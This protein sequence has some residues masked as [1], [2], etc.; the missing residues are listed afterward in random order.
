MAG[1]AIAIST[2]LGTSGLG[3]AGVVGGSTYQHLLLMMMWL[4]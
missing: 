1:F 2:Q 4:V 3:G